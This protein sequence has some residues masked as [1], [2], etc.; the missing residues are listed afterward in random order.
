[1]RAEQQSL[2]ASCK[3]AWSQGDRLAVVPCS[4]FNLKTRLEKNLLVLMCKGN[5]HISC[6]ELFSLIL[7]TVLIKVFCISLRKEYVFL[8]GIS[9]TRQPMTLLFLTAGLFNVGNKLL[10]SLDLLFAIR[11]HIKLGEDPRVAVVNIL[12]SVQEQTGGFSL[13]F[14]FF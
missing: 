2:W 6:F 12:N 4:F 8:W 14:F 7:W 10:V 11:N 5:S 9:G 1:M 3:A 13:F